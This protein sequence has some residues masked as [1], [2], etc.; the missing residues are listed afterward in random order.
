MNQ[1]RHRQPVLR[2]LVLNGVPARDGRTHGAHPLRAPAQD[3]R[4]HVCGQIGRERGDVQGEQH[5]TAHG[6]NVA[7]GV[8]RG[9]RTVLVGRPR[10]A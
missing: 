7:H 10:P 1:P 2:L 6:V 9:D 5:L 3:L 4:H 8:G